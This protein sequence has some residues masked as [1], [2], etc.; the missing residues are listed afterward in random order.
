MKI[1]NKKEEAMMKALELFLKLNE[2]QIT[3][4]TGV[5]TGMLLEDSRKENEK[6]KVS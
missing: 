1:H 5:M 2:E 4:T 6:G 3:L